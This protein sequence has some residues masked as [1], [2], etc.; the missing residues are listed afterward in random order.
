LEE[1]TPKTPFQPDP[2]STSPPARPPFTPS[3]GPAQI[4][5]FD[6]EG[7]VLQINQ[8]AADAYGKPVEFFIGKSPKELFPPEEI[9]RF[10]QD[11]SEI[12]RTRQAKLSI[13]KSLTY[14]DGQQHWL[15]INLFPY[16]D[17]A[18]QLIGTFMVGQDISE[19]TQR[20][21]Q[22]RESE[23]RL[24]ILFEH[25]PIPIWEEDFSL[26]KAI[27]DQLRAAGVED[28]RAYFS[29]HTVELRRLAS[30]IQVLDMNRTSVEFFGVQNKQ[31]INRDL[32]TY[33]TEESL[34]VFKEEMIALAGGKTTFS[35]DMPFRMPDQSMRILDIKLDVVPG[36]EN[37]LARVLTSFSDITAR[38]QTEAALH[39][40]EIR[41]SFLASVVENSSQPFATA[42]PDG[43]LGPF[44][45]AFCELLG[46]EPAEMKTISWYSTLTPAK[47]HESEAAH[48][49]ELDRTGL[50]VRYEKEYLRK[51]GSIVPVELLVQ[52]V[53]DDSGKILMYHGFITDLTERKRGEA[54]IRRLNENLEQRVVERTAELEEANKELEAFSYSV[55]H[56][57]RGPLRSIAGYGH[58]LME[59]YSG[60]LDEDGKEMLARIQES[61]RHMADLMDD[62]LKLSRVN[63]NEM[64][65]E[66][67]DLSAIARDILT[68]LAANDPGRQVAVQVAP[69]LAARGDPNLLRL[70]LENLLNNAWKFSSKRA[71]PQIEVGAQLQANGS[72]AFFVRDNGAGFNMDQA[73]RLFAPF[74][75]L[76]RQEEFS[77]TGIGLATVQR[78]IHRHGGQVWAEGAVDQFAA[79]F[80]TLP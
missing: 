36:Y 32:S 72:T 74:S 75:R 58:L 54:E 59:E 44:N 50:P 76:H 5:Y 19:I 6:L 42:L 67:V 51:D 28:F 16:H 47:W 33:F 56:D 71:S 17:P 61:T 49:R 3:I 53:K 7:R 11:H 12:L 27:F 69:G 10:Y 45:R 48:L 9:T 20:I 8:A 30:A 60:S 14:A 25:S 77:G 40:S 78:I 1:T 70:V 65:R 13:N 4:I 68:Q 35:G 23:N 73:G 62:L 41:S 29:Q 34:E 63:R 43:H 39:E 57:L 2:N 21:D 66:A 37:S 55:S 46:Y 64:H 22:L 80:F 18:G 24:R 31:Q 52:A 26:V 38:L 79:F 15:Q